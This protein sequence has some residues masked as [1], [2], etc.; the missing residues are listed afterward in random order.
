ML[1]AWAVLCQ[2]RIVLYSG[3]VTHAGIVDYRT[4]SSGVV[5]IVWCCGVANNQCRCL[6]AWSVDVV[7]SR[8]SG[9]RLGCPVALHLP[10][11]HTSAHPLPPRTAI[12]VRRVYSSIESPIHHTITTTATLLRLAA[13]RTCSSP[14]RLVPI[15][16]VRRIRFKNPPG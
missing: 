13:L 8:V 15:C 11:P 12:F 16:L 3:I 5:S 14:H 7:G 10:Q 6:S 9:T 1:V 4:V 2:C